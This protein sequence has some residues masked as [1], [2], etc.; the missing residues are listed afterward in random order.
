M[1]KENDYLVYKRDVCKVQKI[2]EKYFNNS[3]YYEL[4]PISDESLIIKVP[5]NSKD[6]RKLISKE[7]T[8][9]LIKEIPNIKLIESNDRLIENEY[10]ILLNSGSIEDLI[11]II[12]TTYLR[13][14][15]RVNDG[16][17]IGDKDGNYFK[18]AEKYLY[19]ELAIS[20]KM[21]YD[22]CKK[23]VIEEVQKLN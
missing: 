21:S 5:V 10:K 2:L 15:K 18:K 11:K 7:E 17:K 16:K 12:K 6:I 1:Y 14:L 8:L 3:D 9:K 22:E 23:Y 19:N 20:L 4:L 13:N